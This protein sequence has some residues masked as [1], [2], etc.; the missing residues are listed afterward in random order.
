LNGYFWLLQRGLIYRY[1]R[2]NSAAAD[3]LSAGLDGLPAEQRDAE[4]LSPYRRHLDAVQALC[5]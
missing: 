3:L 2:R 1:L 4:W 5:G